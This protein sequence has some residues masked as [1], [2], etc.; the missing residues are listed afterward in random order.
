MDTSDQTKANIAFQFHKGTIRTLCPCRSFQSFYD[1]NSI[2]VRL[3]RKK[4]SYQCSLHENFN[5]IKVRLE[6]SSSEVER[7]FSLISIP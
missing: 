2:K 6:R 7:G 1:F 4:A 3:E 5:S